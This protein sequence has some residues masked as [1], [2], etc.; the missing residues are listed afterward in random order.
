M[1]SVRLT[2]SRQR[3]YCSLWLSFSRAKAEFCS[4]RRHTVETASVL[5]KPRTDFTFGAES[6]CGRLASQR[7]GV[8]AAPGRPI[9]NGQRKVRRMEVMMLNFGAAAGLWEFE[10]NKNISSSCRAT[11]PIDLLEFLI[12]QRVR[13]RQSVG[14]C[15]LGETSD[16]SAE[17]RET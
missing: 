6:S 3:S 14:L 17:T 12:C 5:F 16:P 15:P 11:R 9:K 2:S 7:S 13:S 4:C 1:N 10:A 8:S